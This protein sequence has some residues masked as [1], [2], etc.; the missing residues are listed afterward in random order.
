M[1]QRIEY[2][3]SQEVDFAIETTLSTRSYV[4]MIRRAQQIGYAVSLYYFWIPSADVSK[5]RVAQRVSKGGHD[6][7]PDVIERRYGRSV[8]NLIKR[9]IPICDFFTIFGN[10]GPVPEQIA[11]GGIYLETDVSNAEIWEIIQKYE[12]DN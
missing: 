6:I 1:L 8:E 4:S 11:S 7:P 5:A 3:M 10:A 9:Y 12:N 2:L